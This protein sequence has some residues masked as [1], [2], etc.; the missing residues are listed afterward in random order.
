MNKIF[1]PFLDVEGEMSVYG[2]NIK[3]EN[4]LMVCSSLDEKKFE[5]SL[6]IFKGVV[7]AYIFKKGH[8]NDALKFFFFTG[9]KQR[10][11][12]CLVFLYLKGK[13]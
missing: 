10:K 2:L 11:S 4:G 6:L 5:H 3:S 13:Q 12:G 8:I 7:A 9:E 1:F